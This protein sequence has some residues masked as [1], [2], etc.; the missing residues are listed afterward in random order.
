MRFGQVHCYVSSAPMM[1][2][3]SATRSACGHF[4]ELS[5]LISALGIDLAARKAI[6]RYLDILAVGL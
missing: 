2:A 3:N 6:E 1:R 5:D 4:A